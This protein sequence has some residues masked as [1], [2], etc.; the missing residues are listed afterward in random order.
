MLPFVGI[1]HAV[2]VAR[3]GT[4]RP[5]RSAVCAWSY[6]VLPPIVIYSIFI[7][8]SI[9]LHW[10]FSPSHA[11][12]LCFIAL[13]ILTQASCSHL[14][15]VIL[16]LASFM[17]PAPSKTWFAVLLNTHTYTHTS[18]LL[19]SWHSASDARPHFSHPWEE[20]ELAASHRP[21]R[22]NAAGRQAAL[23]Q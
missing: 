8:Y 21:S 16:I 9:L 4:I 1:W 13:F 2:K 11:F 12:K 20:T 14:S 18:P 23:L 7:T 19:E 3:P 17:L 15:A 6:L 5:L 10:I 22:D